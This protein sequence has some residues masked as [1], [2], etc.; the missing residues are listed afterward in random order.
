[1]ERRV[2]HPSPLRVLPAAEKAT[3]HCD[4][5]VESFDHPMGTAAS[6]RAQSLLPAK[7]GACDA[8]VLTIRNDDSDQEVV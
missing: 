8:E 1:M 4:D 2:H 3:Q 5:D 7:E 6:A